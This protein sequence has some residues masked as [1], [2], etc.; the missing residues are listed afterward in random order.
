M[1]RYIKR[2]RNVLKTVNKAIWVTWERQIRNRSMSN[3]LGVPL[4]ELISERSRL[5]RYIALSTETLKIFW[6]ERPRTVFVQNP[7]IVLASLAVISS[8]LFGFMLLVDSHNSGIYPL[9][10][11]SRVLNVIADWIMKSADVTIVT[12]QFLASEVNKRGGE[13]YVMPD[14]IPTLIT[15]SRLSEVQPPS[16]L[17]ICSW[18][19]DEP[20]AEVMEAVRDLD[21]VLYVTGNYKKSLSPE[22]LKELPK[23]VVLLGFV[24][25]ATYDSYLNSVDVVLDLTTR[26]YCL[27]CGAYE[28]VSA[29]KP[30]IISDTK[31]NREVFNQGAVYSGSNSASIRVAIQEAITNI[32]KLTDEVISLKRLHCRNTRESISNLKDLATL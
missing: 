29:E 6:K 3:E 28:S 27:V 25:R 22:E 4:Y 26:E 16:I 14:P 31:V 18:A 19:E 30:M 15:N 7:S 32:D 24:D 9:E 23:N 20:Y 8:K 10:R 5:T 11:R 13:A 17:F 21:M 1:T 12:N 2:Q